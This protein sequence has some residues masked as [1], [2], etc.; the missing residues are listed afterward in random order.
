M[1][2]REG[3]AM[4]WTDELINDLKRLWDGGNSASSCA[5]VLGIT[6]NAVMGKVWRLRL[7]TRLTTQVSR[8]PD[9]PP[10]KFTAGVWAPLRGSHPVTID[11]VT[12]CRWPVS[13]P[14]APRGSIDLF[15]NCTV[16]AGR[17]YC[18]EHHA[19][20]LMATVKREE[21]KAA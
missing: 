4:I 14:F 20:S 5:R 15:C 8:I 12:G 10:V 18:A 13:D 3:G 6:R 9:S 2:R 16:L 19:R 17:S 21:R 11:A 7:P 1:E